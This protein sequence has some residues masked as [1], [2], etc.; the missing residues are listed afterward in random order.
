MLQYNIPQFIDSEDKIIGPVTIRQMAYLA[1]GTVI[2][3]FLWMYKPNVV[4]FFLLAVPIGLFCLA[5]AFFKINGLNFEVMISNII[6]FVSKPTLMLWSRQIENKEPIIKVLVEK[7]NTSNI[8]DNEY[9]QSKVEELAWLMDTYG[10][11]KPQ[12]IYDPT[13]DSNIIEQ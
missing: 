11:N 4:F 13:L 5:F 1:I 7:R 3:G 6:S 9:S 12:K 8:I 10:Q 2:I